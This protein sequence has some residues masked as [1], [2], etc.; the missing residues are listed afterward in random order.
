M[1][2]GGEDVARFSFYYIDGSHFECLSPLCLESTVTTAPAFWGGVV[3]RVNVL[4][5]VV[6][7][8]A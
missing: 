8:F 2:A 5:R 6:R 1:R 4:R 7:S 3:V